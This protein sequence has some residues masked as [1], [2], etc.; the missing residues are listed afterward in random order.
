MSIERSEDRI[1]DELSSH[2][3]EHTLES[4]EATLNESSPFLQVEE[5]A[6]SETITQKSHGAGFFWIQ[7]GMVFIPFPYT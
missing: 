5:D 7:A 6:D 2:G 4:A 1:E 3:T